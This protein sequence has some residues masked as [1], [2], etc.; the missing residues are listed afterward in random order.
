[1]GIDTDGVVYRRV[2]ARALAATG[3]ES[4]LVLPVVV[5]VATE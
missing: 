4:F 1:M 5:A 3:G 2:V